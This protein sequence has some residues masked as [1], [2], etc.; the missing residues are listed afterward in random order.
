MVQIK[1][2]INTSILDAFW[3]GFTGD[4]EFFD[5]D[6]EIQMGYWTFVDLEDIRTHKPSEILSY[7]DE[8]DEN[9]L[10]QGD[11]FYPVKNSKDIICLVKISYQKFNN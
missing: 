11:N 9:E 1:E 8:I 2:L 10:F 3:V 7:E 6:G 4:S 5:K